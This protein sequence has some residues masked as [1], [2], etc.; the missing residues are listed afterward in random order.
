VTP[1]FPVFPY[2]VIEQP[3]V[4]R[5]MDLIQSSVHTWMDILKRVGVGALADEFSGL[6]L[7][8]KLELDK[9]MLAIRPEYRM[10][11]QTM[12]QD[13]R[14]YHVWARYRESYEP[15][16][17]MSRELVKMRSS[18]SISGDVFSRLRHPNPVFLLPGAPPITMPEGSPGR[19]LA[20]FICGAVAK[21]HQ[22][23][24]DASRLDGDDTP[25]NASVLLDT[26]DPHVNA[27]HAMIVSEVHNPEGT[28]VVDMD[29]CHITIPVRSEFTLDGI[30]RSTAED[31]FNWSIPRETSEDKRYEY[32]LGVAQAT[33]SHLLYACSRTVEVDDKPRATRPPAKRG[34]GTPKPPPA[35]RVRR[36]GW[37]VGAAVEDGRRRAA[38]QRTAAPSTGRTVAPHMRAAHPHLYRVGPGRKEIEIKFLGP[39]PVNMAKDDGI[40]IT[41]HPMR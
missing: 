26:H 29:W 37:R 6:S 24:D 39:I 22:R 33:V 14:P 8:Q 19:I 40:T 15:H 28:E 35:A 7:E 2:P 36:M 41:N 20:I 25:G 18:T 10:Q 21:R 16:P 30:A 38:D 9:R 1:S 17:A 23:P 5:I 32:L 12:A 34:K 11:M 27:Y 4:F 3:S 13:V 31:G